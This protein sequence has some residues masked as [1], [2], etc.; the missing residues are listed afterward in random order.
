MHKFS[1]P[2]IFLALLLPSHGIVNHL[3]PNASSQ[4]ERQQDGL[5]RS[6]GEELVGV[7]SF[8]YWEH[9]GK[10]GM[11]SGVYLGEGRVLT[12][13][14]VGCFP[15]QMHDGGFYQ[16]DYASWRLLKNTDGSKSD[17]AVFEVRFE[18]T[19]K[20][21]R[22][23]VLPLSTSHSERAMLLVGTGYTQGAKPI[24]LSSQGKALA[25]LG[26]H[27]QQQ[28]SITWGLNRTSQEMDGP[29]ATGGT[30]S[31]HCF[32]TRFEPHNFA[33]Q[34]VEGDSGG[35]GFSYNRELNRWE[36][37]GCII[38]VSQQ[39]PNVTFG[40][41]TYLGVLNT[42]VWQI[43]G[44]KGGGTSQPTPKKQTDLSDD[45]RLSSASARV[46]RASGRG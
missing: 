38:A 42:Y 3:P 14:H 46:E 28:R 26:Y 24:S 37:S 29:L 2:I 41:R 18:K 9:V 8:P 16:P 21:A 40:A 1:S 10:V 31:T 17:L 35:A 19:S 33:G 11:G 23:G 36:L 32:T 44:V 34:A 30:F 5:N 12:N 15:F 22:L 43:A 4:I 25:V 13:A 39:Q 45:E 27:V 7:E 6:I 20:L